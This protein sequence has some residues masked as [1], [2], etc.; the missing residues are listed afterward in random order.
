MSDKEVTQVQN[1][2]L[3]AIKHI[4]ASRTGSIEAVLDAM[5]RCET[6]S[7]TPDECA[8]TRDIIQSV[9]NHNPILTGYYLIRYGM[10]LE[11][12]KAGQR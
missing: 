5:R 10:L 7:L 8:M 6:L 2:N 12:E 4:S 1:Q 3:P 9:N 11:R